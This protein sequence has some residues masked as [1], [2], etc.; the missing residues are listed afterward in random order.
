MLT[1]RGTSRFVRR[2]ALSKRQNIFTSEA[3]TFSETVAISKGERLFSPKLDSRY[4][5]VQA[6]RA[7]GTGCWKYCDTLARLSGLFLAERS[8]RNGGRDQN[9]D[10]RN[11][12]RKL[13]PTECALG[14][15]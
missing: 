4:A 13:S 12:R 1:R 7:Q 10:L 15:V 8:G 3:Q 11:D 5:A 2:A 9:V 6:R 14:S